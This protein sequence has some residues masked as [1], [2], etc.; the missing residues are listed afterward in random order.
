MRILVVDDDPLTLELLGAALRKWGHEVETASDG[1]EAWKSFQQNPAPMLLS[2]WMM[3][4]CDGIELCRRIREADS[5]IYTYFIMITAKRERDDLIAAIEGG[6]DDFL[7]KPVF[8]DELRAK[9][10]AGQRILKLQSDLSAQLNKLSIVNM[11]MRRDLEAAARIQQSL[12]P[13]SAPQVPHFACAWFYDPCSHVAGDIMN[14]I[15]LDEKTLGIYVLDVAGHGVPAA[16]LAVSV[17]RIL[18]PQREWGGMLK[19]P[20]DE[21]P[22][23]E[24]AAPAEVADRLNAS[25]P[26]T[27]SNRQYF[28]ILYGTLDM[29]AYEF[30]YAQAG[31]PGPLVLWPGGQALDFPRGEAAIG[32]FENEEYIEKTIALEVGARLFLYSDGVIETAN[33]SRDQFG[34]ER[35]KQAASDSRALPLDQS[36]A[37]IRQRVADWR[38]ELEGEDDATLLALEILP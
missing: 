25:F 5:D 6:A 38:G 12:L 30:R 4:L 19:R 23:Y 29:R 24:I 37:F 20:L 33:A 9:I 17:S 32:F 35:L 27:E 36:V 34:I 18:T 7:V 16:L 13:T 15:R 28:T 21:P 8:I 26:L 2:D 10:H 14:I 11:Q 31:H 1:E 22:Y 3:P